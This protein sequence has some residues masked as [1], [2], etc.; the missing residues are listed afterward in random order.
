MLTLI[1]TPLITDWLAR[2]DLRGSDTKV[3]RYKGVTRDHR[4]SQRYATENI[5]HQ[6]ECVLYDGSP[7]LQA[8][9][10]DYPYLWRIQYRSFDYKPPLYITRRTTPLTPLL[11]GWFFH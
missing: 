4:D 2:V 3:A 5:P 1:S 10:N 11:V 7:S 9:S 8:C 6:F